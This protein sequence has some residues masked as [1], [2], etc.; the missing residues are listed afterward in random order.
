MIFV[1]D[2][3]PVLV[4]IGPLEIRWYGV[5]F[6]IGII[7]NYLVARWIFKR[8]G[9]DMAHLDSA[10]LYLFLGLIIGARLGEVIF[11]NASYFFTHPLDVLKIW[12]GGLSSHGA[13]IGLFVAWGIWCRVKKVKFGKYIDAL[14]LGF[15]LTAMFVR[16]GNFFNSEIVGVATGGE[17]GV[18]F[19]RLSEDFPRHPAQLYEAGLCFLIFVVLIFI[20]KKYYKRTPRMFFMFMILGG[21]FIGRF[22]IEF[23]KDLHVLPESFPLSMGQVLSLIPILASL[24]YFLVFLPRQQ[25]RPE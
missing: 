13:V 24:I 8:E 22:F 21:Y 9:Y 3:S 17:G 1:N 15:P 5:L 25:K 10:A 7:L 2:L 6:A 20:Y 14:A 18:V 23:V 19:K 16:I 4:A 11:Y 12:Q